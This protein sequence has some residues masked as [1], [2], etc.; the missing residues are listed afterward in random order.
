MN[1]GGIIML[2]IS[3]KIIKA[4]VM[5]FVMPALLLSLALSLSRETVSQEIP[6]D[7]HMPPTQPAE[8][9]SSGFPQVPPTQPVQTLPTQPEVPEVPRET[10]IQVVKDGR[11]YHM[12]LEEYLLGVMLA[13]MPASFQQ[14]ALRAQA[15]ASR[16]YTLRC[17]SGSLTHA[18]G[19]VCT[20]GQCCQAYI[21]PESYIRR[22]G[23]W[24]DLEKVRQAVTDTAG[25]V[26][27]YEGNLIL[28]TYFSCSGGTTEAAQAVWG[29][30][31]PYLQPVE[32][33][34]EEIAAFFSDSV[35]FTPRQLQ[36]KLGISLSGDPAKWFEGAEYTPGGGIYTMTIGGVLF[37]G[38]ELRS[39]LGL[40]STVFTVTVHNGTIWFQTR[41]YGHRVGMS[42]YGAEAMALDGKSYLEILTHYYGGA[43]IAQYEQRK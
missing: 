2:Q 35:S 25:Q 29:R 34:G 40:R 32:S 3:H 20:S 10:V 7:M 27:L 9:T 1:Q 30:D 33:P 26:L 31:F 43:V 6:G 42:Q 39:L 22:G 37:T 14:E 36:D 17:C 38:T 13:E 11:I 5:G 12:E 8:G 24:S 28:A 19:A 21:S 4:S 16:T 15:V 18:V 23:K 41:G